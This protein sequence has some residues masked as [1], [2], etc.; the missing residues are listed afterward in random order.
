MTALLSAREVQEIL[1]VDKSTVYRMAGDGR[2][3]AVKVGR[4]WRFPE[5]A[6][7]QLL[8]PHD[9]TGRPAP[10]SS[11]IDHD[12][13]QS[14]IDLAADLLGVMMVLTDLDGQP[15]TR[16][17]NP[18]PRFL[19]MSADPVAVAACALE[20]LDL[21]DDRESGPHFQK[22]TLGFLCARSFVRNGSEPVAMVVA[23]GI[24]PPG[25]TAD[26]LYLLNSDDRH[27]VAAALPRIASLV[28]PQFSTQLPPRSN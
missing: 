9:T 2:L 22:G 21:A 24:A 13:A 1:H 10:N 11:T 28:S 6:I 5:A 25:V 23:G 8:D 7:T 19:E 27:R 4:Q 15:I 16:V 17:S 14:V 26:D 3:P 12:F 20:W 18:C